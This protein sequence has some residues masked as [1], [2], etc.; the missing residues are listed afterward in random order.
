[1]IQENKVTNICVWDGN[2]DSWLPPSDATMLIQEET[3]TKVWG[4]NQEETEYVL[5]DSVGNACIGFTY[6]GSVCI[7]NEEKPIYI[8]VK[9]VTPPTPA[10]GEIPVTNTGV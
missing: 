6:D 9:Q 2:T 4:L 10:T 7:T 5:V 1:M 8:P 3:P